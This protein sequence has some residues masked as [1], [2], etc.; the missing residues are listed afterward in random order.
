MARASKRTRTGTTLKTSIRQDT[1]TTA[2]RQN[3]KLAQHLQTGAWRTKK[4]HCIER[5]ERANPGSTRKGW[6]IF[7]EE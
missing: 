4:I 5:I 3:V 2:D 7:F 1:E 6:K